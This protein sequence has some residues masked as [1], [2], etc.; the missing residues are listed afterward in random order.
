V[1]RHA[2][3]CED[4]GEGMTEPHLCLMLFAPVE[5][6]VDL[7]R[8]DV[9]RWT[10]VDRGGYH[11]VSSLCPKCRGLKREDAAKRYPLREPR[12]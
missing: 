4:C 7:G 9:A 1:T 11:R 2:Y 6:G 10:D 3:H 12:R 8:L 5:V